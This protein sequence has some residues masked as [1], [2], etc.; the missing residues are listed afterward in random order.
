MFKVRLFGLKWVII[1]GTLFIK[2]NIRFKFRFCFILEMN[3]MAYL[4]PRRATVFSCHLLLLFLPRVPLS[5]SI[6]FTS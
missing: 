2:T 4:S 3:F 6:S 5:L 1:V